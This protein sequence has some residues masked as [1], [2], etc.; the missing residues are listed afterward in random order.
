MLPG[1]AF[2][3]LGARFE[4]AVE[5]VDES[6]GELPQ[7]WVVPDLAGAASHSTPGRPVTR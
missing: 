4:A 2:V 3:V 5:D 7:L 1:G 6:V